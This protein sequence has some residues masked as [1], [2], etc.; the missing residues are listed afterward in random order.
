MA[1]ATA[2]VGNGTNVRTKQVFT[3]WKGNSKVTGSVLQFEWNP[4]GYFFLTIAPQVGEQK[5]DFNEGLGAKLGLADIGE[6][7]NVLT[8]QKNGLGAPD[9]DKWK[10]LF[11]KNATGNTV[12]SAT[13][14]DQWGLG[15]EISK[16]EDGGTAN[17]LKCNLN[18]GEMQILRVFMEAKIPDMLTET[19]EVRS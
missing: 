1:T 12:I 6:F 17:R 8:G 10:G 7:L 2:S 9:G 19:F 11:H 3:S 16:K 13:Y 18:L 14:S 5:Y 4:K 15:V